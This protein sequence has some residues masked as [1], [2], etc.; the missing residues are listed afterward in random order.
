MCSPCGM[1]QI[2]QRVRRR[3]WPLALSHALGAAYVDRLFNALTCGSPTSTATISGRLVSDHIAVSLIG[4][5]EL[6]QIGGC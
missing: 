4:L 1:A 6:G 3:P 5:D 2:A